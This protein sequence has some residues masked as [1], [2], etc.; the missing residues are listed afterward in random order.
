MRLVRRFWGR[1][2]L[3]RRWLGVSTSDARGSEQRESPSFARLP[4]SAF[5][6]FAEDS[7]PAVR[8]T[9]FCCPAVS[10]GFVELRALPQSAFKHSHAELSDRDVLVSWILLILVFKP[11]RLSKTDP[12][13]IP[14]L[15]RARTTSRRVP[16]KFDRG[17]LKDLKKKV[18]VLGTR[19]TKKAANTHEKAPRRRLAIDLHRRAAPRCRRAAAQAAD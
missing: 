14:L 1:F 18:H 6:F 7:Y 12:A 19:V 5:C 4:S 10:L 8:K 13:L 2:L 3:Y 17:A 9:Y 15:T 16:H 11:T